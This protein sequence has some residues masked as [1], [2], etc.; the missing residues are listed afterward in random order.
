MSASTPEI[1]AEGF[2]SAARVIEQYPL[3]NG[4]FTCITVGETLGEEA[5]A[6]YVDVFD[7]EEVE[8]V[9]GRCRMRYYPPVQELWDDKRA[10]R[11]A[12]RVLMLCFAAAMAETGDL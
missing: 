11:T 8:W 1:L 9:D 3:H 7:L 4:G 10:S 5:R 2:R 6:K 12:R